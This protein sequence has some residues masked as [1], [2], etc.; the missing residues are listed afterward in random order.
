VRAPCSGQ[1]SGQV[2]KLSQHSVG[3]PLGQQ[4]RLHQQRCRLQQ[5]LIA[6]SATGY[7]CLSLNHHSSGTVLSTRVHPVLPCRL[8]GT[9]LVSSLSRLSASGLSWWQ[10]VSKE[11]RQPVACKHRTSHSNVQRM[12]PC[13]PCSLGESS[14]DLMTLSCDV[15]Y[16]C[17]CYLLTGNHEKPASGSANVRGNSDASGGEC[18]V[19]YTYRCA[20]HQHWK[21]CR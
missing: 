14:Y 8:T 9:T 18:G 4:A 2:K 10:Q 21:Q 13:S 15:W 17:L 20:V 1:L 7:D 3:P 5:Q 11:R 12:L 16:I 6:G 19:P